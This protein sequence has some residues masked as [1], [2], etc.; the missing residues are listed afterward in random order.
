LALVWFF[1]KKS[2]TLSAKFLFMKPT[3]FLHL[4]AAGSL[5]LFA[6]V[7][8]AQRIGLAL[9]STTTFPGQVPPIGEVVGFDLNLHGLGQRV[10]LAAAF[11]TDLTPALRLRGEVAYYQLGY[12]FGQ[13]FGNAS[14][15]RQYGFGNVQVAALLDATVWRL[16]THSYLSTHAGVGYNHVTANMAGGQVRA[17]GGPGSAGMA[18]GNGPFVFNR[19]QNFT[20]IAGA[21]YNFQWASGHKFVLS[22][23]YNQALGASPRTDLNLNVAYTNSTGTQTSQWRQ[24]LTPRLHFLNVSAGF[25]FPLTRRGAKA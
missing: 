5:M 19:A 24:S 18:A 9:A 4:L 14:W 13:D 2:S 25:Y 23:S 7:V 11:E 3:P 1:Q 16:C 22:A 21:S 15:S 12:R 20:A 8:S 6:Q 10:G 17:G